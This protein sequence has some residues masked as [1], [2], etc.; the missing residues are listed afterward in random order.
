MASEGISINSTNAEFGGGG[1]TETVVGVNRKEKAPLLSQ[2]R[3]FRSLSGRD[4]SSNGSEGS[5]PKRTLGTFG[6]VFAPVC[7]SQFS[8]L[9]FLRVGFIVGNLGL[10]VACGSLTLAY[11]ILLFTILSICAIS[12][13]GAVEGGGAYYMISRTLGPEFGGAIGILF[14]FAN[15]FS[16]ALYTTGCVE[17]LV[18]NFGESGSL[19][20]FLLDGKWYQFGYG[21]AVNVLN[22]LVCL[23]GAGLFAKLT[24]LIYAVVLICTGSVILS[25]L[26]EHDAISVPIPSSNP[27]VNDTNPLNGTYTGFS[28]RTLKNNL[29]INY[30]HDYTNCDDDEDYSTCI[31]VNFAMT[32]GVLFSGVTGIM[33][34]ANMSGEMKDPGRSIPRGTLIAVLFTFATYL[35]LFVLTA[36]T[37]ERFLLTNNYIFMMGIS[38]WRPFITIGIITATLSASLSN[39]IGSSRVLEA[40]VK[41][42]IY[43]RLTHFIGL[44]SIGSNPIGAVIVSAI[45]VECVLLIG[46]LNQIAEFTSIFFLLSYLGTN[47]ACLGLEWASAPN[48]RPT[49]HYFS[50]WTSVLGMIGNGAMM[51]VISP[52]VAAICIILLLVLIIILHLRSP[53]EEHQWGSI[54]QALIF[55]QVRKY[56]LL[57]DSRKDHV[58]FWRPQMLLLVNNPRSAC[59]LIDFTNDLKKSG[60]YVLGHVKVGTFDDDSKDPAAQ[61]YPK[62]MALVDHLKVKA[63]VEVTVAPTVRDGLHHLARVSGL[64]AMKPNTILLGFKDNTPSQDFFTRDSSPF[65]VSSYQATSP[66]SSSPSLLTQA[67][68]T[69]SRITTEEYVKMILDVLNLGKNVCVCRHF[70]QMDKSAIFRKGNKQ[71]YFI[72]VWPVD[73]L[74]PDDSN[75]FGTTSLFLMQLATIL[76]MVSSWRKKTMLRVFLCVSSRDADPEAQKTQVKKMLQEL[77]INATIVSVPW[78][79]VTTHLHKD[80]DG[81]HSDAEAEANLN[82][83]SRLNEEYIN[84]V[85]GLISGQSVDTAVTFL[86]LPCPPANPALHVDYLRLLTSITNGL[87]PTVMVHGISAV[88]TTNL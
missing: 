27:I 24:V 68:A 39:I 84:G 12:T 83:L 9:L 41:D 7:L 21:S 70:H 61:D 55:H 63:F 54:S 35:L 78:D 82:Y 15:V 14:F 6:G 17:G 62:W 71:K 43:G 38:L 77:R 66:V 22:M 26:V 32:F 37:T 2:R 75:I 64:G 33:A 80:V 11:A 4:I 30:S 79:H 56:L 40:L 31:T 16:S 42:N 8:S 36:A 18:D 19:A 44:I 3:L 50:W 10:L 13:N 85:N 67:S 58:K 88:T 45:M 20:Q 5:N 29:Y 46:G 1:D 49:F 87:K 86:H 60:L 73:F 25:Y 69:S 74:N 52:S 28:A 23:V 81:G 34:G 65:N 59:P 72:D 51:F 47:L 76:N 57:L 48:F 53:S